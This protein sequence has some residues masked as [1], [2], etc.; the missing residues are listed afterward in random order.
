M[1][2]DAKPIFCQRPAAFTLLELLLVL[3]ILGVMAAVATP[4][5]HRMGQRTRLEGV[6][7]TLLTQTQIARTRAVGEGQVVELVVDTREHHCYLA[8]T[9]LA[10]G[11]TG[12]QTS[13]ALALSPQAGTG[14]VATE[15]RPFEA[16]PTRDGD[17]VALDP[18]I[19][20]TTDLA[21]DG[22]G[23]FR[24]VFEPDG[25]AL[26]AQIE[27]ADATGRTLAVYSLSPAEPYRVGRPVRQDAIANT[28]FGGIRDERR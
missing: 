27:L 11:L 8:V 1:L 7:R 5:L 14:M 2:R 19:T 16:L 9:P 25:S 22:A 23:R 15:T 21:L 18:A 10:L 20:L 26:A 12:R 6:A 13:S 28:G 24:L 17:P 3:V 4:S